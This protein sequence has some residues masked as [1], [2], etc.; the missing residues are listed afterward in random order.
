MKDSNFRI[1][2]VHSDKNIKVEMSGSLASIK[3]SERQLS[4]FIIDE[5]IYFVLTQSDIEKL[6]DDSLVIKGYAVWV[7]EN[8]AKEENYVGKMVNIGGKEPEMEAK[9]EHQKYVFVVL[10]IIREWLKK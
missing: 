6:E 5:K 9:E 10:D 7:F 8:E 4:K 3:E 1:P 2:T